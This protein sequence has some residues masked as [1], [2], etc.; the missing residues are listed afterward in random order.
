MANFVYDGKLYHGTVPYKFGLSS[1]TLDGGTYI[2]QLT[3]EDIQ[4]IK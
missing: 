2:D 1:S 4:F 3:Y